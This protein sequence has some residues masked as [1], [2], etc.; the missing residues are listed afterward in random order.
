MG[1]SQPGRVNPNSLRSPI[2]PNMIAPHFRFRPIFHNSVY[3]LFELIP[4]IVFPFQLFWNWW[5]DRA[6][7]I[8]DPGSNPNHTPLPSKMAVDSDKNKSL[9]FVGDRVADN[10][11]FRAT[12]RYVGPVCT[13]KDPAGKWI[14]EKQHIVSPVV[15]YC[16]SLVRK[17]S[18]F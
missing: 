8:N 12:V 3:I 17:V 15:H 14:G 1:T 5:T 13:A 4:N 11:G 9:P 2:P 7:G 16:L 6:R 18:G 10:N